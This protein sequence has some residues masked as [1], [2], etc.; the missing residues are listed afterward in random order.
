MPRQHSLNDVFNESKH[1]ATRW[2][3]LPGKNNTVYG[4]G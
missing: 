2:F 4:T 1:G 3:V